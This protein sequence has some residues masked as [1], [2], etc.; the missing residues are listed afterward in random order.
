MI[1]KFL[2][3]FLI[4][5]C[6]GFTNDKGFVYVGN[7]SSYKYHYRFHH[8]DICLCGC[9]VAPKN[10]EEFSSVEEAE[11]AGYILCKNCAK[12]IKK[13]TTDE[14]LPRTRTTQD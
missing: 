4:I 9:V 1:K 5:A 7:K 10:R 14:P 12:A 6:L 11:K 3:L 13:E 8:P 2:F